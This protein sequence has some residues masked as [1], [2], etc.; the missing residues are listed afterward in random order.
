MEMN[1]HNALSNN[2]VEAELT[3]TAEVYKGLGFSGYTLSLEFQD[4]PISIEKIPP[5][6]VQYIF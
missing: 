6:T 1:H 5:L 2:D 3:Y 4:Y